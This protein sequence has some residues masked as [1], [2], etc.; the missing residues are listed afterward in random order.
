[1]K[2]FRS[3]SAQNEVLKTI[4]VYLNQYFSTSGR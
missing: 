2:P 1:M 4:R 3:A